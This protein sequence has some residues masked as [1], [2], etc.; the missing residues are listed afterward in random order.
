MRYPAVLPFQEILPALSEFDAI[1]DVRSLGEFAED[2]IPGAINCPVLDDAQRIEVGTMY[3]QVGSFEAKKLG[4]VYVARNI[5]QHIEQRFIDKP[6]GWKP[7]IYCWR[8]GNR[9]G[10]MAHILAK[11]GWPAVQLDGGYKAYRA[12]VN[13]TLGSLPQG[14]RFQVLCGSTGSGKSRLL[15]AL[16]EQ[17]AQVLDLE[18]LALHRGSV[19]GSLPN[20]PQPSQKHFETQLWQQL[21]HADQA[22]SIF[23]EAESKKIGNLRVPDALMDSMR[24]APCINVNLPLPERVQLLIAEYGHFVRDPALLNAQLAFLIPLHGKEK[25]ARWQNLAQNGDTAT[26]VEELLTQHY[27]PAYLQSIQRNFSGYANATEL[28]L[29]DG[30]ANSFAR[31]ATFLI[32][33]FAGD[34]PSSSVA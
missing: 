7:L 22:Q 13:A 20:H 8:G 5:A 15:R 27:D 10:A 21:R 3:K 25:I 17:G 16:T 1:I 11:I 6:H 24:A 26:M 14:L 19:L 33:S 23:I 9:S 18:Q 34:T 4:A 31:A 12:H 29:P 30:S 28:A 2:H 32:D